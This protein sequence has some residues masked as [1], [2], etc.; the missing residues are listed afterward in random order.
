M[1]EPPDATQLLT[2]LAVA[3]AG[4][5]SG[6]AAGLGISQSAVSRRL[7]AL[8]R[9]SETPLVRRGPQG[10]ALTAQ[11]Q[12]LL[13]HARALEAALQGAAAALAS[14]QPTPLP[15]RIGL[16]HHLVPRLSGALLKEARRLAQAGTPVEPH[17]QEGYSE[18][19]LQ[20]VRDGTLDAAVTL[21]A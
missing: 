4:S 15:L 2:L 5:E 3:D 21:G 19:L 13:T 12:A 9:R 11:G 7:A 6:A 14:P 1:R 17:L 8:Q 16:S 10:T 20:A 18:R